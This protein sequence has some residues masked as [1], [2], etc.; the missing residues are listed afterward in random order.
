[1]SRQFNIEE[2]VEKARYRRVC[3]ARVEKLKAGTSSIDR[4][5]ALGRKA[6]VSVHCSVEKTDKKTGKTLA[7]SEFTITRGKKVLHKGLHAGLAEDML[8]DMLF[9]IA[10]ADALPGQ[11]AYMIRTGRIPSMTEDRSDTLTS[12]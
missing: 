9:A 3:L 4:L 7:A 6:G 2:S 8:R 5:R 10:L 11:R 12:I 1:M